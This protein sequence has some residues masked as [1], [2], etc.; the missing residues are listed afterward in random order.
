MVSISIITPSFNQG[1]FIERTIKS[2]INQGIVGLEYLVVDGGSTDNTLNVL[3][4][5]SE[6][7]QWI[8]EEDEGQ[9]DAVNKGLRMTT[10]EIIG[11]LNSDDIYYPNAIKKV[12]DFFAKNPEIDIIYGKAFHIDV[13]GIEMGF[14][15]SEDWN[16][17]RLKN[18]CYICQPAVFFRRR[19][20]NKFGYLDK[21]LQ[22]CMDY[23]YWLRLALSGAKFAYLPEVLAG[24]RLYEET[25]TLS[26]KIAVH[27]EINDMFKK[28]L[29][30]VPNRWLSNYAHVVV[31]VKMSKILSL[32]WCFNLMITFIV[33]YASL[34]WNRGLN[35]KLLQLLWLWSK[36]SFN[37]LLIWKDK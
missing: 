2:V 17:E 1:R 16:L 22:Y 4:N 29:G 10:G 36:M 11:W 30:E 18:V 31:R 24:S 3:K 5:Y 12:N 6:Y 28:L 27:K 25:K 35:K 26:S 20:I 19:V 9:A 32:P 8:H 15:Y 33:I 14:Y 23:E 21:T 13:N 37:S 34:K 7:I